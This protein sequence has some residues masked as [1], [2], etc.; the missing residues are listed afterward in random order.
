ME[1]VEK[2]PSKAQSKTTDNQ[3]RHKPEDRQV[4]PQI[5]EKSQLL[6]NRAMD[7]KPEAT[8]LFFDCKE[9]NQTAYYCTFHNNVKG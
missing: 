7:E 1:L 3:F 6:Q 2:Q 8:E 9:E 4:Q 5:P